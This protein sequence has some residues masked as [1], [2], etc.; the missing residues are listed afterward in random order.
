MPVGAAVG[1]G[2]ASIGGSILGASS[3]KK[4]TKKAIEAQKDLAA[5]NNALAQWN[6]GQTSA[7]LDPYSN[8]G[9]RASN[10]LTEILLGPSGS[11]GGGGGG[12]AGSGPSIS[13]AEA[14]DSWATNALAAL[15][16]EVK[17]DIWA[18][19]AGISDPSAKLD[20]IRP[21][22]KTRDNQ[23]LNGFLSGNPMPTVGMVLPGG[24]V[25]T[26]GTAPPAG[27][28]GTPGTPAVDPRTGPRP[29]FDR[30]TETRDQWLA[31]LE[32]WREGAPAT[33][34]TSGTGTAAP[35]SALGAWDTFRNSTNYQ[36]RLS[37]G[38]RALNQGYAANGALDSG[39]ARIALQERGQQFASNEL[40]NWMNMLAGQQGMGMSAAS[41][42]A[43][44]GQNLVTNV[45]NNNAGAASAIS[46]G[47]LM[48]GNTN[49]NMWAGI[50]GGLGQMAGAYGSSYGAPSAAAGYT[51]PPP[52][53]GLYG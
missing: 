35:G 2:A 26:D 32:A 11:G 22:L 1:A 29:T 15:G 7:R 49:A 17:G 25:I 30:D 40:A 47:A 5:Q 6:F 51:M 20:A 31:E 52:P 16:S 8:N 53:P 14:Q 21:L 23:V 33:T 18:K 43:G 4:A 42:L 24:R 34:G 37:E 48:N 36:W 13:L 39:A 19:V 41:A 44:V 50:A 46:N 12:G 28:P 27:T 9:L 3:S 45:S 10:V 38:N